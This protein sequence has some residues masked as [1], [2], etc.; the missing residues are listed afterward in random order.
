MYVSVVMSSYNR[1]AFVAEAIE[2]VLRQSHADF[3][4]III[5]D[6]SSDQTAGIID[7]YAKQ[8]D[9][10][11][12]IRHANRGIALSR[13]AGVAKSRFELIAVMDD[14]D[15][16][17]HE[18][19]ERQIEFLESHPDISVTSSFAYI[20]D[21]NGSTIGKSCPKVDME[22]GIK[23]CRP[24]A[25]LDI[26]HPSAMFRKSAFLRTGGY[27]SSLRMLEDR[28]LWGRLVTQGCTLAV[29]PLFLLKN[30]RHA[31]NVSIKAMR[32]SFEVGG[33]IDYNVIRRLKKQ[34]EVGFEEYTQIM[35]SLPVMMR[36]SRKIKTEAGM[37]FRR[38]TYN[39]SKR[40]WVALIGNLTI[41]VV[42]QPHFAIERLFNKI[43]R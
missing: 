33:F 30:R 43:S 8:D 36:L 31:D 10:I 28:D 12:V 25:F 29:Q 38:A 7:Q 27:R 37:A 41:A 3:E 39:Y 21:A 5:D 34:E 20:I 40:E 24:D 9:R 17:V 32:L 23:E 14:D 26:I 19:L 13:N 15:V 6:G 4:F 16:M 2:S 1:Q 18:R 42:L 35:K 22:R 11:V